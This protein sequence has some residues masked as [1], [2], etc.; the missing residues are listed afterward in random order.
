MLLIYGDE[1]NDI[2]PGQPGFEEMMAG[3][4]AFTREVREKGAFVHGDPLDGAETAT[5][6]RLRDG[7]V[8]I[9]DGP[10]IETK[11][12]LGGFYIL[13]CATREAAIAYAAKIP[14]A[15]NGSIE[16]RPMAGHDTRL[17]DPPHKKSYLL[18]LYGDETKFLPDPELNNVKAHQS[19]TAELIAADEFMTGDGLAFTKD[20]IT[21]RVRDGKT[22]CTDGPFAETR[23]V[24]GGFYQVKC[25]DLD[26]ALAI[27]KRLCF[28]ENGGVEVRPVMAM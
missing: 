10:F 18:A 8:I 13:E 6:L 22:L 15:L 2:G 1:A 19:L 23:E 11:E 4:G 17:F 20:A 25:D 14:R 24:L 9:S 3:Y 5:S 21:V 26:R 28:T 16:V 27:A 7:K 12:Q